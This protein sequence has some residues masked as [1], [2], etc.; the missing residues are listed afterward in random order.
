[1]D[2][3]LIDKLHQA[4]TKG[5]YSTLKLSDRS[6]ETATYRNSAVS[7]GFKLAK[8]ND[9][10]MQNPLIISPMTNRN[11]HKWYKK[12]IT[13]HLYKGWYVTNCNFTMVLKN[14][15]LTLIT[16]CDVSDCNEV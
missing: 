16:N 15:D 14:D 13:S 8:A 6:Q 10:M 5:F 12:M 9:I 2:E 7:F 1:M 4:S 3:R 11:H